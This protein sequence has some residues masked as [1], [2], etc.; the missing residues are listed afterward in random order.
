MA[1]TAIDDSIA[2]GKQQYA[3]DRM[4]V[5]GDAGNAQVLCKYRRGCG[6]IPTSTLM[7]NNAHLSPVRVPTT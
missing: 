1:S 4:A 6:D 2:T 5:E 3:G 7:S